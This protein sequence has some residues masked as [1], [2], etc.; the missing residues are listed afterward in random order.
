MRVF[1]RTI[2]A[3]C[4][5]LSISLGLSLAAPAPAQTM[6]VEAAKKASKKKAAKIQL[7]KKKATV[8]VGKSV[9]LK[10][11][12]TKT[13][14]K[15]SSSRNSV[16]KVSPKGK[17]TGKKA[18]KA[19]ITAKVKKKK[20][21]CTVTVKK[22]KIINHETNAKP[23]IIKITDLVADNE[24]KVRMGDKVT[25][26]VSYLPLN[27]N[28]AFSPI[29]TSSDTDV[30]TVSKAGEATPVAAGNAKIEIKFGQLCKIVNITVLESKEKL[31]EAENARYEAELNELYGTYS[32]SINRINDEIGFVKDFYG[33]FY[34]T[35]SQYRARVSELNRQI[36]NIQKQ[37]LAYSGNTSEEAKTILQRLKASL[38]GYENELEELQ[39]GWRGRTQIETLN[40]LS[41]LYTEEYQDAVKIAEQ[42][43]NEKINEI[44]AQE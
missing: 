30:I 35:E 40:G 17:V 32:E 22:K 19:V 42:K 20:Y 7:N 43:H 4:M 18:G 25:T 29:F 8:Y 6:T 10:L 2:T 13:K 44:N 38:N 41:E 12:G 21:K 1:K 37:M 36:S 3:I 15:W 26:R 34:G 24:Y 28:E 14:V 16:A 11:K 33:Y 5:A 27:A 39:D 9:Q 31:K 23:P